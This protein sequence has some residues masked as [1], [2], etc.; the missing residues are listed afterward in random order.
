L[1]DLGIKTVLLNGHGVNTQ[2]FK[3]QKVK[4]ND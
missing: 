3:A 2:G 4:Q 1:L